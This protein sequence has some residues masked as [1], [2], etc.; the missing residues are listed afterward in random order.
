MRRWLILLLLTVLPLQFASAAVASYCLHESEVAARHFG[1]HQHKH[2]AGAGQASF[3]QAD[4]HKVGGSAGLDD[5]D[6]E[7]CHLGAAHPLLQDFSK[8]AGVLDAVPSTR[9]VL[10]FGTRDPDALDRPNWISLA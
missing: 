3:E 9:E 4:G 7:Y 6:C 1:H 8:T 10:S 5:A 2:H